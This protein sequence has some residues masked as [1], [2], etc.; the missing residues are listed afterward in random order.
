MSMT[1]VIFK[2]IKLFHIKFLVNGAVG[3]YGESYYRVG[4]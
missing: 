3:L 1:L 4:Y 2:V